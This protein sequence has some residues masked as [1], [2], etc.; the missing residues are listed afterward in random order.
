MSLQARRPRSVVCFEDRQ[1]QPRDIAWRTGALASFSALCLREPGRKPERLDR[2]FCLAM[3]GRGLDRETGRRVRQQRR[4]TRC[5]P[6]RRRS[7]NPGSGRTADKAAYRRDVIP[8]FMENAG[9]FARVRSSVRGR[10]IG[11]ARRAARPNQALSADRAHG[12]GL[13]SGGICA[14]GG[15]R[16]ILRGVNV[17]ADQ[18]LRLSVF[19]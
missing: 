16:R 11:A 7:G 3:T 13:D 18:I 1:G 14:S 15:T 10:D 4:G 8:T 12:F 2:L 17:R 5:A 6:G 19:A 9:M